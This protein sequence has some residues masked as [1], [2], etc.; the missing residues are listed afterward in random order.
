MVKNTTIEDLALMVKRGFDDI[1]GRMATKENLKQVAT[2]D[3]L[4]ELAQRSD[5]RFD[6]IDVR[7]DHLDARVG[8]IEADIHEL[9]DEVVYRHEFEDVLG[10]VKYLERKMGIESG[11]T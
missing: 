10:R 9:R 1:T 7:L 11:A 2:K 4:K 8:R 5:A 6:Q 3:D